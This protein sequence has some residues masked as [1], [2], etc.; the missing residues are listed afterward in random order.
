[1][2]RALARKLLLAGFLLC[3]GFASSARS[4]YII[5][6]GNPNPYS[7]TS[8][9]QPNGY[10]YTVTCPIAV[11]AIPNDTN[12]PIVQIMNN[13]LAAE[14]SAW[15]VNNL[16]IVIQG[17]VRK[18]QYGA[19]AETNPAM[20]E[21]FLSVPAQTT[22]GNGGAFIALHYLPAPGDPQGLG[23]VHWFQLIH[24]NDPNPKL[25]SWKAPKDVANFV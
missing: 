19:W 18:Y 16:N 1:M 5:P 4:D 2:S 17:N 11:N 14:G 13:C 3:F 6:D 9:V 24:T 22:P 8:P 23:S 20:Q 10:R 15:R 7:A 21:G 25:P 12:V